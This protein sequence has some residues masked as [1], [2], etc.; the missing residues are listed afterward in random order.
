MRFTPITLCALLALTAPL[1][2]QE[3]NVVQKK[4][5]PKPI[6]DL[7]TCGTEPEFITREAYAG[8]WIWKW[9]CASNH[10]NQIEAHVFSREKDGGGAQALRFPTPYKGKDAWL[11]ELSNS[12]FF[13]AAREFNHFFVDPENKRVCRTEARW[14]APRD[15]L[16]P[17]L[18][19]WRENK[20]C[21]GNSGWRVI[22]NKKR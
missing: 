4:D 10:A 11:E 7:V 20:S 6:A 13:P 15:P 14:E 3:D 8:G 1:R 22:I 21:E 9:Q 17:E 12:E 19:L 18:V 16:K 2:A 5:I